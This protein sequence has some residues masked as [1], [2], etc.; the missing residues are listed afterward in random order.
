MPGPRPQYFDEVFTPEIRSALTAALQRAYDTAAELH[1]PTRGSNEVTFGVGL[2][3]YAVFELEALAETMAN[4]LR[5]LG[6]VPFRVQAG[7][8]F[9]LGCHR[10]GRSASESIWTSFPDNAAAAA[11]LIEQPYLPGT[12]F[13]PEPTTPE[14]GT[15]RSLVLA[16]LGNPVDGLCA[17]YLC[18]PTRE[19]NNRIREWGFAELLWSASTTDVA[20]PPPAT[21]TPEEF[22]E[23]VPLVKKK[24]RPKT[25]EQADET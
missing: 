4:D 13:A 1:D 19:E 3:N 20:E 17:V 12:G 7:G 11:A 2:Y 18:V 22:V 15:A 5:I 8:Q 24:Q 23:P 25:D 6:K 21:R 9:R 16:H 10:V 14:T